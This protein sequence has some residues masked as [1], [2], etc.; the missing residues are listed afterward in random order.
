MID[1]AKVVRVLTKARDY[2][3]RYGWIKGDY[4]S[5]KRGFCAA[6]A[7]EKARGKDT[8]AEVFARRALED[9]LPNRRN[10]VSYN[11]ASRRTKAQVI[12]KFNEAIKKFTEKK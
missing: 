10:I 3:I 11:D 6:G 8:V 12:K 9:T 4:G 1:R 5:F 2:I 7:I